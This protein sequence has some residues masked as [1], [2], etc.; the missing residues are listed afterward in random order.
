[1]NTHTFRDSLAATSRKNNQTQFTMTT[2]E[3]TTYLDGPL[4][5]S[6]CLKFERLLLEYTQRYNIE[7]Q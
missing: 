7:I 5:L 6:K 3:V 1:M 4:T 2:P